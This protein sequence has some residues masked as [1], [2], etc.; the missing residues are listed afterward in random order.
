MKYQEWVW[1]QDLVTNQEMID[2]Q[3]QTLFRTINDLIKAC[4]MSDEANGLLVEVALDELL[5]YAV[6]HF[7]EEEALMTKHNYSELAAH[8]IEHKN[9]AEVMMKFKARFDKGEDVSGD[10]IE[11]MHKWLINHIMKN[12][13]AAM[14]HC[15]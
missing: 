5:K 11:F 2:Y 3:H 6:Y 14:K 4:N 9:F 12:D 15:N 13:K 8:K 7:S 1:N 10:L